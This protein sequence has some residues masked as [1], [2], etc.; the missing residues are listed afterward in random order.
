MVV[1]AVEVVVV[2]ATAWSGGDEWQRVAQHPQGRALEKRSEN[3]RQSWCN[4][5]AVGIAATMQLVTMQ[6]CVTSTC[7]WQC[8]GWVS[9]W[10]DA[11]L[12]R[13][14]A[15]LLDHL[16]SGPRD[17]DRRDSAARN[18]HCV[19]RPAKTPPK[20]DALGHH[21]QSC[22]FSWT[23][24]R[25]DH[26]RRHRV[27]LALGRFSALKEPY[28]TCITNY[29]LRY[30]ASTRGINASNMPQRFFARVARPAGRKL[31]LRDGGA[32]RELQTTLRLKKRVRWPKR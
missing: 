28:G 4:S 24:S 5:A 18:A 25:H 8:P 3:Q 30:I 17:C 11:I 2:V 10:R 20:V 31:D 27:S 9:F 19:C 29:E 7:Q 22:R 12:V 26:V 15:P 23:T 32:P 21:D 13:L 6:E 14:G 1:V 16:I